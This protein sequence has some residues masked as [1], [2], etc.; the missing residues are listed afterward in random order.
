MKLTTVEL[1]ATMPLTP[2]WILSLQTV[3]PNKPFLLSNLLLVKYLGTAITKAHP[4]L[5]ENP[6]SPFFF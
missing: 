2:R 5:S 4:L 1:P 3:I 6:V